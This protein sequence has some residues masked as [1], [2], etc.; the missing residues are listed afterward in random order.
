[1]PKSAIFFSLA[2]PHARK[3]LRIDGDPEDLQAIFTRA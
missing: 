2:K 1:M 3:T